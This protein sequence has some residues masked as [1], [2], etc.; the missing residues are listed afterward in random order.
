MEYKT[1]LKTI[2]HKGYM[3]KDAW[4]QWDDQGNATFKAEL[5]KLKKG[6][7]A[8]PVSIWSILEVDE[9]KE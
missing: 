9:V 6:E 4:T 7:V 8:L 1:T 2:T 3:L 5:I